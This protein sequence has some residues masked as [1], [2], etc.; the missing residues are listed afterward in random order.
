MTLQHFIG[1]YGLYVA[2]SLIIDLNAGVID[3]R[4]LYIFADGTTLSKASTGMGMPVKHDIGLF[5]K[6]GRDTVIWL[7]KDTP[8]HFKFIK[9][10]AFSMGSPEGEP[11]RDKDESPVHRVQISKPFYLGTFEVTQRQFEV[12]MGYN[13]S[14]FDDFE[15]SANHPVENLSWEEAN[16][17]IEKLNA[18]N[19]GM[20]RL[21]TEAEWEYACRAGTQSAYYWGE[22]M[23]SNGESEYAWANSR[24]FAM[25]HP[26]GTKKAN[27]WGLHDMA[28]NVWEWCS[29]WYGNYHDGAKIDP[30]G[31]KNGKNKVFRGGSWYDFHPS[32]RC[33]NRHRHGIDKGYSAIGLRLVM[34]TK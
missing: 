23:K 25:T 6:S 28:G 1:K 17:F 9:S 19:I 18:L 20:F 15:G 4:S 10:G 29:D 16:L 27:E 21:P 26:V 34:E 3:Y 7:N 32:H 31:P 2:L 8:L 12:I 5:A 13:P 24:S 33:A 22:E 14:V 30:M 11:G